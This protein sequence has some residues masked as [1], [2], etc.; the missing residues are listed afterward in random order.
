MCPYNHI[1]RRELLEGQYR[2]RKEGVE[3]LGRGRRQWEVQGKEEEDW[4]S[5]E[6]KGG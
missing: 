3:G 5:S 4:C 2:E 1:E 6:R